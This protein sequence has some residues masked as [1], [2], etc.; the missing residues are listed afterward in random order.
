MQGDHVDTILP[1]KLEYFCLPHMIG[2]YRL[3]SGHP[4]ISKIL[5]KKTDSG[6]VSNVNPLW[7]SE[8]IPQ[9]ESEPIIW[10]KILTRI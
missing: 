6:S 5:D 7:F 3:E 1:I 9:W 10:Q 2:L 4:I 8:Y